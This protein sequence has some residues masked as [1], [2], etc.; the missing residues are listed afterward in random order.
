MVF[1]AIGCGFKS[2]RRHKGLVAEWL[3]ALV[4]KTKGQMARGFK[5]HLA[6][7]LASLMVE[8]VAVT[9]E[10]RVQFLRKPFFR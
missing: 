8:Y 5:S 6:Q 7:K 2:F 3:I 9:I 4:L 1:E 10:M